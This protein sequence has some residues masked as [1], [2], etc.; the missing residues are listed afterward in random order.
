MAFKDMIKTI[1]RDIAKGVTEARDN[2][3]EKSRK[4]AVINRLRSVVKLEEARRD[5]AY[6]ALGRYYYHNLRD[7]NNENTELHCTAVDEAESRIATALKHLDEIYSEKESNDVAEV[8]ELNDV[9]EIE[10]PVDDIDPVTAGS[11]SQ[12]IDIG[13]EETAKDG[14]NDNLPFE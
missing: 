4:T 13:D 9:V 7:D 14:E 3:A 8:V 12:F 5:R 11:N 10:A 1:S 6:M 2:I